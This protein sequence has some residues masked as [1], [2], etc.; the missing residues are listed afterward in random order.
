MDIEII[1]KKI[2]QEFDFLK[3]DIEG[4]LLFG[5][6]ALGFANSHSDIDVCLVLGNRVPKKIFYKILS[7]PITEKYDIKLFEILPLYMKG[8]IIENNIIV[9]AKN[10][11]ELS[12][13][14]Y[15][16]RKLWN[17]QK[18]AYKKMNIEF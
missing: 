18:I 4:I 16:W 9:W 2:N 17:D 12:Y 11:S 3:N 10:E 14:L 6:Y 8:E 15:P 7:S 5:S 13:Y 1:K